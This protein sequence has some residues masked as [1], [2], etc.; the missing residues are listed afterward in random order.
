M[1][2]FQYHVFA[3]DQQKPEGVPCCSARGS[4][5][6]IE[7]LRREIGARGLEDD[8]QITVCGS[9]GLC[10]HGPNLIV[11]PEGV[12]YSGV[13]PEDVPEIVASHFENDTPVVRLQRVDGASLRA[14]IVGREVALSSLRSAATPQNPE[15]I[16]QEAVNLRP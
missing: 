13:T 1:E 14:E 15:V 7:A 16:R 5:R 10:E 9:L 2:P 11:Y 8:V 12:W 3:C 6:T 4:A